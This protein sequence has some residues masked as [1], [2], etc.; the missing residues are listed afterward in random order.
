MPLNNA[1]INRIERQLRVLRGFLLEDGDFGF[2]EEE[3]TTP[4]Y[5][6]PPELRAHKIHPIPARAEQP[7]HSPG[8]GI[9]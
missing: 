6:M 9:D 4:F 5:R 2:N 1:A 7:C 3:V 8:A